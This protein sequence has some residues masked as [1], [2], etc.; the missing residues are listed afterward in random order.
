MFLRDRHEA[1][2]RKPQ[3]SGI[4]FTGS[5]DTISE[6]APLLLAGRDDGQQIAATRA[7]SLVTRR[8]GTSTSPIAYRVKINQSPP[9]LSTSEREVQPFTCCK[10]LASR[11]SRELEGSPYKRSVPSMH[12]RRAHFATPC[13]G[14]WAARHSGASDDGS[15][16]RQSGDRWKTR[17]DVRPVCRIFAQVP[18][19]RLA[20]RS[21]Q[22]GAGRQS[23]HD[24][25][26]RERLNTPHLLSH[27][28]GIAIQVGSN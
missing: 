5:P 10:R 4:E 26:Y 21:A 16:S 15:P 23:P 24:A 20:D 9:T 11:K 25:H 27:P 3:F 1:L 14:V 13:Q 6:W 8:N 7:N 2:S 19:E 22:V 12:R 18:Q 17:P 28:A